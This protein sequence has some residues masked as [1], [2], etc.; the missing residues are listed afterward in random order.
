MDPLLA[1]VI[2][3]AVL[4]VAALAAF[5]L[6]R[7]SARGDSFALS[8]GEPVIVC[9][10]RPDDQSIHGVVRRSDPYGVTLDAAR[11]LQ[12]DGASLPV[13]TVWVPIEAIAFVQTGVAPV[14]VVPAP[15]RKAEDPPLPDT[16]LGAAR[17]LRAMPQDP[18]EG[19]GISEREG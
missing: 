12:P 5:S 18:P 2:A 9:T 3:L 17:H 10:R 1:V 13:G 19:F 8:R 4:G 16:T 6:A 15:R 14:E 11:Y 7:A